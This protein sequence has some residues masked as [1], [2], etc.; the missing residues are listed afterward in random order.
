MSTIAENLRIIRSSLPPHVTL[1]A[2]SKTHTPER[3]L[4]AYEAGQH[5]FG[6]NKVQEMIEKAERLPANIR[7]H[8]IGHLQSN[9]VKHI[10]PFVHLIHS[11]DSYKILA[12][13]SKRAIQYDRNLEVL[14]QIYIAREETKFGLDT[15]ELIGILSDYDKG[16]FPSVRIRGLMGMATFT[17]NKA[18]IASEFQTL[19]QIFETHSSLRN[20]DTLSMGMSSDYLEA[21]ANGSN[22]VRIGS[23]IFGIRS[24]KNL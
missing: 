3:I 20:W 15:T 11:V 24:F 23:A 7:W 2:V 4:E 13:I 17:D 21:I 12:E 16:F 18:Q 10:A 14:L 5:D 19:R 6:E 8:L 1:I 22:M 9:K